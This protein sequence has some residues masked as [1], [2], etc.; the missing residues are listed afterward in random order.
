MTYQVGNKQSDWALENEEDD[1][2]VL[3]EEGFDT[4]GLMKKLCWLD[5]ELIWALGKNSQNLKSNVGEL[6]LKWTP[7]FKLICNR[8]IAT[9]HN[10]H[11]TLDRAILLYAVIEKKRVDAGWNIFNNMID[12]VKLSKGFLFPAM[13]TDLCINAEVEVV[14]NEKKVK[15]GFAIS[16]KVSTINRSTTDMFQNFGRT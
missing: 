11:I 14:K 16:T 1:Y 12:S 7:L 5:K 13:V 6:Q 8:L 2:L 3:M 15:A 9:T 10:S 4:N